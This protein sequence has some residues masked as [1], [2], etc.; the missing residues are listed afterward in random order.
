M[1]H[2]ECPMYGTV[3]EVPDALAVRSGHLLHRHYIV[4]AAAI[5]DIDDNKRVVGLTLRRNELRRFL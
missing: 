1:G 4:P 3:P 2:V 5:G